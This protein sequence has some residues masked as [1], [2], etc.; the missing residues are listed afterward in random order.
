M[1]T[2]KFDI[3]NIGSTGANH[4]E[5]IEWDPDVESVA[6]IERLKATVLEF[7]KTKNVV[8][9]VNGADAAWILGQPKQRGKQVIMDP[10]VVK[11]I[12]RHYVGGVTIAGI[13]FRL[14]DEFKDSDGNG[15][16]FK[17]GVIKSVLAQKRGLDVE[18]IDDLRAKV[19]AMFGDSSKRGRRKHSDKDRAE[20]VR[21]HVEEGMSGSAIGKLKKINSSIIN[22]WLREQGV[23]RNRR[24]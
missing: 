8:I 19:T 5:T 9:S 6:T 2:L 24:S 21:L 7:A 4:Q 15:L 22:S 3:Y 13:P 16:E 1:A 11:A 23:Q 18:G 17:E 20:W 12:H 14:F 10:A